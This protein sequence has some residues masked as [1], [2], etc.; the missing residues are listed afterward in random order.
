MSIT[1]AMRTEISQLYVSLFGRAP[2]GEGLGFW[3]SSYSKGNSLANIAQSMYDTAPARAYYPLFATASEV[4]TT[5]YTNVLGRAPDAEGL[6]FWVKEYSAATTQGAFFSK[7]ISN[8]VNYTGTDAAGVTSKALF[9]NKVAVAQYYGE[10]N[11]SV[12]GATA[13]LNGVTSAAAS[14]DAAKAVITTAS[15]TGYTLSTTSPETITAI[16]ANNLINGTQAT[17]QAS[18]V[19]IGKAGATN[20]L[21]LVDSGTAAW[22]LPAASVSGVQTVSLRNINATTATP[23]A[24]QVTTLSFAALTNSNATSGY[25]FTNVATNAVTITVATLSAA[26]AGADIAVAAAAAL[27]AATGALY[28]ATVSGNTVT[29]TAKTAGAITNAAASALTLG[30]GSTGGASNAVVTTTGAAL[31][32]SAGATDTVA[33]GNFTGATMFIND[34]STSRV[35]YTGL[36]AAQTVQINGNGVITNGATNAQMAATSTVGTLVVNGGVNSGAVAFTSAGGTGVATVSLT[37]TGTAAG[38]S[39]TAALGANVLTSL[40]LGGAATALNITANNN[41]TTGNVTG[42]TGTAATITVTGTAGALNLGTLE[43]STVKTVNASA[44]AGGLTVTL[45]ANPAIAFTG[46]NGNDSVTTGAVLTTGTVSGGGGTGDT[47]VVG[48]NLS[49]VNT[50]TLAAKYT[51][52]ETLSMNGIM[53]ASLISG[54][55]KIELSGATNTVTNLSSSQ[56]VVATAA[57]GATTLAPVSGTTNTLNLQ[58]G[59]GLTADAVASAGVLTVTGHSTLNLSAAKGPTTTTG[60]N[61]L[62]VVTGAMVGATIASV[63]LTGTAFQ[64]TDI[65]TTLATAF[66]GSALTGNGGT[67]PAGLRVAGTATAGSSI[68]GSGVAD[69]FTIGGATS[70][71]FDGGAGNDVFEAAAAS[72]GAASTDPTLI[73]GSGTDIIR[74]TDNTVVDADFKKM[75]GFETLNFGSTADTSSASTAAISVTGLTTN[76]NAAFATGLTVTSGTLAN[77]A[78]YNFESLSYA[79]NVTITLTT[80]STGAT[81]ASNITIATGAGN[82]TVT[83]T[84][85]AWVGAVTSAPAVLTIATG[86]GVDTITL[87]TGTLTASTMAGLGAIQIT[88]GT[89]ADVINVTSHV[90]AASDKGN[91][92][93]VVA[94]GDSTTT[95]YDSITGFRTALGGAT[96]SD[97]IDFAGTSTL[98]AYTAT[99]ATGYTSAQLNVTVSAT[100]MVTLAGTAFTAGLTLQQTIDAVQSVVNVTTGDTALFTYTTAGVTS[101]YIFNNNTTDSVVQLVGVSTASALITTN[102]TVAG[103]IFIQ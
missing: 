6:A 83:V 87:E 65:A 90:N 47:L 61:Q 86:S 58:L 69:R 70:A 91:I 80:G 39:A 68:V 95:A 25:S 28:T 52:F 48:T 102:A 71:S 67:S 40:A 56:S 13:A 57:I 22:T 42:F 75:T 37:S 100:G 77:L 101:T 103:Q 12:A 96:I 5:F 27:N 30:I 60:A 2:D 21:S 31:V 62:A 45:N 97:G 18:D 73:G 44:F 59:S 29:L 99:A 32:A 93:F 4:V 17:F 49:H 51:N 20:T 82:D 19:I 78:S 98:N 16:G 38:T 72:V 84:A 50:A 76:A 74:F 63:N 8:V 43:A 23:A 14:V 79:N 36:T 46:G 15:A 10:Q 34:L 85:A 54:I 35:D 66:N 9:A 3:V 26:T 92:F 24:A 64:F 55:T 33:A 11:G 1:V 88:A 53:D 81:V 89:G 7:L 94:A 41:L